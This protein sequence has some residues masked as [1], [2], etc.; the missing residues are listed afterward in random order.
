MT[1]QENSEN[2]IEIKNLKKDYKMYTSK[3][4]RLLE[5]VLPFYKNHETF[6]AIDGLDLELKKGEVLGILG[7]NGAGK[8]TLLKMITG[9]AV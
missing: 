7:K 3:K 5:A 2:I 9:L 1:K 8:S 4:A 6:S